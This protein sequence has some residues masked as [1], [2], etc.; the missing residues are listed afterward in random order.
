MQKFSQESIPLI[1]ITVPNSARVEPLLK[2]LNSSSLFDLIQ[3]PAVM[4]DGLDHK[5]SPNYKKQKVI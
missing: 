3:F 1:I 2:Q 4:Y 5:F